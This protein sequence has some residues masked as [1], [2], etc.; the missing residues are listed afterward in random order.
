MRTEPKFQD[1]GIYHPPAEQV[2]V[3]SEARINALLDRLIE[4]VEK[5]PQKSYVLSEFAVTLKQFEGADTEEQD[6]VG[7]YLERIMDIL[8]IESSDGLINNWRYGFNP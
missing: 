7:E 4:G 3:E 1:H 8:H 5:Q 2:R 6:R